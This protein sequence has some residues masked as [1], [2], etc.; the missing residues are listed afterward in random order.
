MSIPTFS[1]ALY[2]D[3]AVFSVLDALKSSTREWLSSQL[4]NETILLDKMA[5]A[6]LEI[7][8]NSCSSPVYP[9]L[10]VSAK[11]SILDRKGRANTDLFAADLGLT[12]SLIE[13]GVLERQRTAL[14]QLKVGQ[15]KPPETVFDI[16]AR[17]I[18]SAGHNAHSAGRWFL[19]LCDPQR[20]IWKLGSSRTLGESL[21]VVQQG[22]VAFAEEKNRK[23]TLTTSQEWAGVS[24]WILDWLSGAV[25]IDSD[26]A[27]N[28]RIEIIIQAVIAAEEAKNAK[29]MLDED[30]T[31]QFSEYERFVPRVHIEFFIDNGKSSSN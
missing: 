1:Q 5:Q 24:D 27:D 6:L 16:D 28:Q 30:F 18:Y 17:Q 21:T 15:H 9:S 25:G 31:N 10:K 19:A 26:L 8:K 29:Q 2:Q 13:N 4:R 12:L 3:D 7:S 20:G 22:A 11:R 14:F 23:I